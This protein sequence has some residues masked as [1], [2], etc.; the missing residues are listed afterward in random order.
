MPV[1]WVT[2][3]EAYGQVKSLRVWLEER[4][5][6]YVLATRRNDDMITTT[7]GTARAD[8]LIASLP[9]QAWCRL[10]AG[11]GA[12]PPR[13]RPRPGPHTDPHLL[14]PRPRALAPRPAQHHHRGNRPLRLLGRVSKVSVLI[15]LFYRAWCDV[16]SGSRP[17]QVDYVW[18]Q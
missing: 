6:G 13:P 2:A 7:M 17:C 8:Q 4:D 3:D 18:P 9:A 12:R 10:S 16:R 11:A 1:G 5:V 14:A 15:E